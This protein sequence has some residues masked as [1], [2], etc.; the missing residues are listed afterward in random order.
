MARKLGI[1]F[2]EPFVCWS[3]QV[4]EIFDLYARSKKS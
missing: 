2:D 3:T 1:R 4:E